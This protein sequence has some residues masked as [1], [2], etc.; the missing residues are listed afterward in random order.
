MSYQII[1]GIKCYNPELIDSYDNFPEYGFSEDI[2]N[3]K[4]NFWDCSRYRL[5]KEIITQETKFSERVKL[6]EVGCNN[7]IFIKSL[8]NLNKFE[9]TGSEI[10]LKGLIIAKKHIPNVE[11]IQLDITAPALD[12][13]SYDLIT[14]FDVLEHIER[15]DLAIANIFNALKPQG[16][17][18]I[19]VPQHKFMYSDFDKFL[20]HQRRYTRRELVHKLIMAGFKINY[21]SS[22]VFFLFPL[23]LISR[24]KDSIFSKKASKSIT[25]EEFNQKLSLPEPIDRTFNLLMKIDE[26][27]IKN[28]IPLPFGGTLIV[29]AEK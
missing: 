17:F 19:S 22:F 23:M 27:L 13:N 16:K 12:D 5:F 18:I 29:I 1:D 25:N 3:L 24:L 20:N 11:F 14:A 8:G 7:G 21:R 26:F 6:L 9:I 10:Y 15:D 28:R 4:I 2:N